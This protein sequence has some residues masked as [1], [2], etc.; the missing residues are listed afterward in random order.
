MDRRVDIAHKEGYRVIVLATTAFAL[1]VAIALVRWWPASGTRSD[2]VASVARDGERI[3]I[4]EIRPTRQSSDL[5]PPP[6][7]PLPPIL[8][9]DDVILEQ[10]ELDLTDRFLPIE[11]PGERA[12]ATT[13]GDEPAVVYEGPKPIRVVEPEYTRAAHRRRVRAEIVVGVRVDT[14]GRV[15]DAWVM[16]R[17]LLDE[18][19]GGAREVESLGYGLEEAAMAAAERCL[20]RPARR[21]GQAVESET[22][23]GFGFGV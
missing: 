18:D 1:L 19:E 3:Q 11:E 10:D 7:A 2:P 17:Y 6:P 9:A 20:F 14:E 5:K 21:N 4:E 8:V 16:K 12:P 15:S 23:L 13:G 22:T